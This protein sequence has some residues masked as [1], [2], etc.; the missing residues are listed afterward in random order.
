VADLILSQ[1]KDGKLMAEKVWFYA[2]RSSSLMNSFLYLEP[3][4][5]VSI[6]EEVSGTAS[7]Y[8]IQGVE[9]VI[10][11]GGAISFAWYLRDAGFDTYDYCKW[12]GV[13][14]TDGWDVGKWA[15]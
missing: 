7:D 13:S 9:A 10:K 14:A 2:N 4:D 1:H 15:F 8:F 11:K 12:D 3:G 5:R 6:A